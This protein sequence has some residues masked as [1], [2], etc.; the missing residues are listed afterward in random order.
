V[1]GDF[2]HIR[3]RGPASDMIFPE[4]DADAR[5]PRMGR[6]ELY[7]AGKDLEPPK[8]SRPKLQLW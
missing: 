2:G 1:L 4:G 6:A 7:R 3:L 5:I 8:R